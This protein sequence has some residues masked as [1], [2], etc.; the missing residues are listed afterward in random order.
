MSEP[1]TLTFNLSLYDLDAI[2]EAVGAYEQ[3]AGFVVEESPEQVRVVLTDPHPDV[4]DLPD[5]FANHVLWAT[6]TRQRRSEEA[7]Q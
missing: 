4:P 5:H 1:V 2:A 3:L 6:I 7:A